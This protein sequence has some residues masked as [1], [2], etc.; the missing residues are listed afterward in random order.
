MQ[1]FDAELLAKNLNSLAEVFDRKPITAGA[2]QAWFDVLKEFKTELVMGVIIGWPKTHNKFPAPADVWK[3]CNEVS[4]AEREK[5]VALQ[6][7]AD[8]EWE[9]SPRGSEFLAK[10]RAMLR[11]P[12]PSPQQHWQRVLETK[13]P[14]SIGHDYAAQV[15]ARNEEREEETV[16]F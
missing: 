11:S 1:K 3:A 7:R 16:D 13:A 8:V 6:K 2:L 12:A 14:G 5:K 15:L 4:I 9:R 10:M